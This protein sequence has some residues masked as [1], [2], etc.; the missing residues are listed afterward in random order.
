MVGRIV[1]SEHKQ[2][3]GAMKRTFKVSLPALAA[4]RCRRHQTLGLLDNTHAVDWICNKWF[5]KFWSQVLEHEMSPEECISSSLSHK[6]ARVYQYS[7]DDH[8]HDEHEA[9]EQI[10]SFDIVLHRAQKQR[11]FPISTTMR[12]AIDFIK[13]RL[14]ESSCVFSMPK[15]LWDLAARGRPDEM[16]KIDSADLITAIEA[17]AD[18]ASPSMDNMVF[19]KVVDAWPERKTRVRTGHL[20]VSTTSMVLQRLYPRGP[21]DDLA[22]LVLEPGVELLDTLALCSAMHF[23]KLLQNLSRWQGS[24]QQ[25]LTEI[26]PSPDML[27]LG[28]GGTTML[29]LEDVAPD[30]TSLMAFLDEENHAWHYKGSLVTND[31]AEL[32]QSFIDERMFAESDRYGRADSLSSYSEGAL[33]ELVLKGICVQK[34]VDDSPVYALRL[35][36]VKHHSTT[37]CSQKCLDLHLLPPEDS[38][39]ESWPKLCLMH[40]LSQR[41]WTFSAEATRALE[42]GSTICPLENIGASK[43]YWLAMVLNEQIFAK[44]GGLAQIEHHCKQHYYK[45]LLELEDLSPV[46][47]I[48]NPSMQSDKTFKALLSGA[49]PLPALEDEDP[50]VGPLALEAPPEAAPLLALPPLVPVVDIPPI[51]LLHNGRTHTVHFDNYQHSSGKLRAYI[52]CG[53]HSENC[54]LYRYPHNFTSQK[55][56]AAYLIAWRSEGPDRVPERECRSDHIGMQVTPPLVDEILEQL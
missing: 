19:F 6:H 11:P 4:A 34:V 53:Y 8:L 49:G 56:C 12:L 30:E 15:D 27:A 23:D 50:E 16:P 3:K 25:T 28:V 24:V 17:H 2:V 43:M 36:C 20:E 44:P 48:E 5:S 9:E 38:Q 31:A 32:A 47:A 39:F 29:K 10:K 18:V 26:M 22:S 13:F 40:V 51:S 33:H 42:P 1:E 55:H 41:G 52:Q 21:V 46:L 45:C 37:E 14:G 35:T 7:M 54:R